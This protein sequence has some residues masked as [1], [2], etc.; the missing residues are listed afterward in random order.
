[1]D[2]AYFLDTEIFRKRVMR[3][4]DSRL[5]LYKLEL[6][7]NGPVGIRSQTLIYEIASY[8][9]GVGYCIAMVI[10]LRKAEMRRDIAATQSVRVEVHSWLLCWR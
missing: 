2:H 6:Q 7:P 4:D 5:G 10:D 8:D 1:V 9:H 3:G